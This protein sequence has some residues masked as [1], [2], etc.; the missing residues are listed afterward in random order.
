[1]ELH[2]VDRFTIEMIIS[3]F[4]KQVLPE[5]TVEWVSLIYFCPMY[6]ICILSVVS[7]L[8]RTQAKQESLIVNGYL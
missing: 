5:S 7:K 3:V 6:T 4:A 8:R 2:S 1:M